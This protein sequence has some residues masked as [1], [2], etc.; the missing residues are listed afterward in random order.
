MDTKPLLS[1]KDVQKAWA[2]Y[3]LA[4]EPASNYE[5]LTAL[6]FSFSLADSL[7]K[8]YSDNVEEYKKALQRHLLLYNS[9]AIFGSTIIGLTLALEEERAKMMQAG[10]DE[11]ELNS[12]AEMISNL[13]IG[14]M[15]PL[16]GIGDTL[17]HTMISPLILSLFIPLAAEGSWLGGA[18][19]LLV[20][21][22][23]MTGL[24]YVLAMKGYTIGRD[25]VIQLL[26]SGRMGKIIQIASILGLFMMGAL[27]STYVKLTTTLSWTNAVGEKQ[28]LQ[29]YIDSFLPQLLPL[30]AV[31]A[32]YLYFKKK[33]PR[34]LPVIIIVLILAEILSF[35]GIV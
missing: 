35:F 2:S 19:A 17:N 24:S 16:A 25:S 13:K 14:L 23:Y 11:N 28:L 34:F 31:G 8:L 18:G 27:S 30:L 6:G 10:A 7:E 33:G 15:G 12:S 4:A 9:E 22:A 21:T 26:Q 5:R 3:L 29:T 32:I 1:K 20:W